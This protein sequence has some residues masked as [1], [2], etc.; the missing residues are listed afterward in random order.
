MISPALPSLLNDERAWAWLTVSCQP[1][2]AWANLPKVSSNNSGYHTAMVGK[3]H[4]GTLSGRPYERRFKEFFGFVGGGHDYF[5]NRPEQGPSSADDYGCRIERNGVGVKVDGYLTAA[6]GDE[7]ARI[8][9]QPRDQPL[10]L[11][12]AFNAPHTPTQAPRELVNQMHP[13]LQG[14]L[15]RTYAAQ[16]SAMDTRYLSCDAFR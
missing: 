9:R 4:L 13:D 1:L 3:W 15:R 6:F 12:L 10:F 11:Y 16:I 2:S 8:I 5:A 7:A 14:G